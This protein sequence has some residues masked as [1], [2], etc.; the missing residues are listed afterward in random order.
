MFK[1]YWWVLVYFG[2]GALASFIIPTE[3]P[4]VWEAVALIPF[5]AAA[6]ILVEAIKVCASKDDGRV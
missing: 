2:M 6:A 5:W 1:K 4:L 3:W